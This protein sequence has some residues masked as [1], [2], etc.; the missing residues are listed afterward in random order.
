RLQK[1]WIS[2]VYAFF[3]PTPTIREIDGRHVH[4]F[5]CSARGCKVN[6]RRYLDTKDARSTG[7]MRKHVRLCWGAEI[8]DAADN[9]KDASEVR[10]NIVGSVQRT[11]SIAAAFERKGKG[12]ISYSHRQHTRSETRAEIVRWLS[13]NQ[14]PFSI[15]ADRGFQSLMK[16][17]RPE[18]YL[19]SP[20]T[21]SR[22]TKQVFARTRMRIARMLQEY[23]RRLNFTTDAWTSPN[24]HSYVAICVHLQHK[25]SPMSFPLDIVELA[26][27]HTGAALAIAF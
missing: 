4:E 21:V 17:G 5:A 24:H 1:E 9:A 18:Y 23:D 6:V 25:G 22:D 20:D 15:I 11:G 10:T 3:N 7:N 14:R 19:P 26:K 27:S 8:L 16:T 13:E 2:P 12:K